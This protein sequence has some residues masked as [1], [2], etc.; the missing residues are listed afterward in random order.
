MKNYYNSKKIKTLQQ[1]HDVKSRSTKLNLTIKKVFNTTEEIL[2]LTLVG[3]VTLNRRFSWS[4]Y[5]T[6]APTI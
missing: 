4:S 6:R 2:I 3:L 5:I 1:M